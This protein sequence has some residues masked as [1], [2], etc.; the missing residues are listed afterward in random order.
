[1]FLKLRKKRIELREGSEHYD[2]DFEITKLKIMFI[3]VDRGQGDY[4]IKEFEKQGVAASFKLYGTG[5][6]T[7]DI[8]ELLGIGE[9]K[10]DIVLSVV[11]VN[12][13][14]KLKE[15]VQERFAINKKFKGVS[16]CA[17]INSVAGVLVYKYLANVR[18]NKRRNDDGRKQK[19]L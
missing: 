13:I 1:M 10:K 18:E 6:A 9:T 5:T 17:E 16:F 14:E 19:E 7:K 12:D 15:I 4:F 11:K 8:Y 2:K 3:I